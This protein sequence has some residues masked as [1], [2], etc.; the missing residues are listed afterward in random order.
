MLSVIVLAVVLGACGTSGR[1]LRDPAPGATAPPRKG[2]ASTVATTAGAVFDTS[3]AAGLSITSTAWAPGSE[4]PVGYTC[5]G[6]DESPPLTI[7]GAPAGTVE[8]VLV[9]T[10]QDQGALVHWVVAGI[11]PTAASFATGEVPTGAVQLPNADGEA[12]WLGPCPP[13]G[14]THVYD[15]TV[16]ALSA[17]S[18]LGAGSTL[19]QVTVAVQSSIS[20]AAMTGTY[21]AA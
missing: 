6:Q 3:P 7:S 17:P 19:D 4:I 14:A 9:V 21:T 10:D 20:T 2:S 1:A 13:A 12:A 16:H 15:F 18:G 8:L 11:S 5:E